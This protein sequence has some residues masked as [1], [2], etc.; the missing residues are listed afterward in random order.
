MEE[1]RTQLRSAERAD[2]LDLSRSYVFRGNRVPV[3]RAALDRAPS[4]SVLNIPADEAVC[5]N[6]ADTAAIR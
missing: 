4:R 3:Q 1:L 5:R 6:I 2:L